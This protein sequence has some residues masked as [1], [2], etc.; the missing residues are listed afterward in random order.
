MRR[1]SIRA[2]KESLGV[3]CHYSNA[4]G[5][6]YVSPLV[7]KIRSSPS[8]VQLTVTAYSDCSVPM[9]VPEKQTTLRVCDYVHHHFQPILRERL[10]K[11]IIIRRRDQCTS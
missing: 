8:R 3:R 10:T 11:P 4:F 1:R 2:L 5:T 6:G 9:A 7:S